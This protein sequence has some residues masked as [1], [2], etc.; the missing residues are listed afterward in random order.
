MLREM[1][2]TKLPSEKKDVKED[3]R[4]VGRGRGR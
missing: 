4:G 1:N 3:G 2:R